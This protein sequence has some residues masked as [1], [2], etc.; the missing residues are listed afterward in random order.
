[1]DKPVPESDGFSRYISYLYALIE[2]FTILACC[3]VHAMGSEEGIEHGQ[4]ITCNESV[5]TR[6]SNEPWD[7]YT[8]EA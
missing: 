8:D 4:L 3:I 5:L 7:V 2:R 1:M 6:P